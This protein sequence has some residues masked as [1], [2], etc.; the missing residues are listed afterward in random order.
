MDILGIT[1]V[2]DCAN[3]CLVDAHAKRRGRHHDLDAVLAPINEQPAAISALGVAMKTFGLGKSSAPQFV[4]KVDSV[5]HFRDVEDQGPGQM[6][7]RFHQCVFAV[8][9]DREAATKVGNLWP[10]PLA[11]ELPPRGIA[12]HIPQ[13][14]EAVLSEGRRE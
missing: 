10:K 11:R 3:I 6:V 9:G 4:T 13:Q 2:Y 5:T 1:G 12:E 8:L 14:R 7:Q